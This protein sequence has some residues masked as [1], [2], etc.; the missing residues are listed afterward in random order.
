MALVGLY[1]LLLARK[2]GVRQAVPTAM[3]YRER[4]EGGWIR[5]WCLRLFTAG[6]VER[7]EAAALVSYEDI[8]RGWTELTGPDSPYLG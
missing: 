8:L 7:G 5:A 6:E 2:K 1:Q 4:G 3:H